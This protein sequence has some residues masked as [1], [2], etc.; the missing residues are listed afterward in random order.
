MGDQA[1]PRQEWRV[2]CKR[3]A[4]AHRG[5][6][7]SLSVFTGP[8]TARALP[9]ERECPELPLQ[10][11]SLEYQHCEPVVV[12][13]LGGDGP[14]SLHRVHEPTGLSVE[15]DDGGG[16]QGLMIRTADGPDVRLRVAGERRDSERLEPAG[17]AGRG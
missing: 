4:E 14:P 12:I 13:G 15:L 16:A 7:V 17:M 1:I 9:A 5:Q 3:F 10:Q 8:G 2:F 11:V 6:R